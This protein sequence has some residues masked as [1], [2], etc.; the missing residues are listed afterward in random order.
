MRKVA[1]KGQ[2]FEPMSHLLKIYGQKISPD[3]TP[4]QCTRGTFIADEIFQP[5]NLHWLLNWQLLST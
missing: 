5:K 3:W 2:G 1:I 4:S